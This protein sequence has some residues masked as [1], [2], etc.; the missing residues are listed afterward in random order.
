MSRTRL[1]PLGHLD[2]SPPPATLRPRRANRPQPV[3]PAVRRTSRPRRPGLGHPARPRHPRRHLDQPHRPHHHHPPV[4]P[5]H[6]RAPGCPHGCAT[7][8]AGAASP[9]PISR[10][11]H[12]LLPLG[13][14]G[15][16]T[17]ELHR[18]RGI[19]GGHLLIVDAGRLY[20][21]AD[22]RDPGRERCAPPATPTSPAQIIER[23]DGEIS[24]PQD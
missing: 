15:G 5:A 23:F 13:A 2:R 6:G 10:E 22:R 14:H 4:A 7:R 18:P 24:L 19:R 21:A 20:A 9:S 8:G 12:R 17:A 16:G 1:R 3:H 11:S